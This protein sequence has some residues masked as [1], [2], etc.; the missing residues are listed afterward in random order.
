MGEEEKQAWGRNK[1]KIISKSK[2]KNRSVSIK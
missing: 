1:R 2:S